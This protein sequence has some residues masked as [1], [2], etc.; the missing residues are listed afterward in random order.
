MIQATGV[1]RL[2]IYA[3]FALR[4]NGPFADLRALCLM[5]KLSV[6]R[7]ARSLP[8]DKLSAGTGRFGRSPGEGVLY[9]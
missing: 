1:V 9:G 2:Q 7:F 8:Y 4:Q 3:L 5:T 6:C